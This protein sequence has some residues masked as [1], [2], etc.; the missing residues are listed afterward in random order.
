MAAAGVGPM[1][2][3]RFLEG[4]GAWSEA[5][6]VTEL[7]RDRPVAAR[8][9]LAEIDH[10]A[11]GLGRAEDGAPW[12]AE[13]VVRREGKKRK[14][15][16]EEEK[17][18]EG[19]QAELWWTTVG[20]DER[21]MVFLHDPVRVTF[22]A[23]T[24]SETNA[25]ERLFGQPGLKA[26]I[27]GRIRRSWGD[28][29][30]VGHVMRESGVLRA[31][32]SPRAS[33]YQKDNHIR[34]LRNARKKAETAAP[35]AHLFKGDPDAVERAARERYDQLAD[36]R[37]WTALLPPEDEAT[38]ETAQRFVH[39]VN[40]E[41]LDLRIP[42]EALDATGAASA[43]DDHPPPTARIRPT[44]VFPGVSEV[45]VTE[46]VGGRS[47]TTRLFWTAEDA[48]PRL[49]DADQGHPT[50][51]IAEAGYPLV[52]PLAG[53]DLKSNVFH[54]YAN[55]FA[56]SGRLN[57]TKETVPLYV[58]LFCDHV[59]GDD[60]PFR[61]IESVEDM[62]PKGFWELEAAVLKPLIRPIRIWDGWTAESVDIGGSDF[63]T[64]DTW[65]IDACVIYG[66]RFWRICFIL[67]EFGAIGMV[68]DDIILP[69]VSTRL[70]RARSKDSF[71]LSTFPD[72]NADARRAIGGAR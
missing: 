19:Q 60:G 50:Y 7:M 43:P 15:E 25:V 69:S 6:T 32:P 44:I 46:R 71:L 41:L 18:K 48:L 31:L 30:A 33:T 63:P 64:D 67:A 9:F 29:I 56:A 49:E 35:F 11:L 39:L 1:S 22:Q 8:L 72:H 20:K 28:E 65:A 26:E 70:G 2:D 17:E 4:D 57:L 42:A 53:S 38:A 3:E 34:A 61:V 45:E 16:E 14:E 40:A 66:G 10:R 54:A 47:R 5:G 21:L 58:R 12:W 24:P 37:T 36:R 27:D 13:M 51:R 59:Q 55:L 52:R 23:V 62:A 68:E